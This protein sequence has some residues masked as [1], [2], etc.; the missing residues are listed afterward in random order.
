MKKTFLAISL[1]S[2]LL[3]GSLALF[4]FSAA[5]P[6]VTVVHASSATVAAGHKLFEE[7][8]CEHCHGA[9]GIG[10]AGKGPALYTVGKRL[11]K[12]AIARQIREGGSEMPAFGSALQPDEISALVDM[13]SKKK[14]APKNLPSTSTGA[15]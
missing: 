3:G 7:K 11:K 6:H 12:D 4:V 9:N 10:V 2:F 5:K 15:F 8:G 13:L 1:P 14:K